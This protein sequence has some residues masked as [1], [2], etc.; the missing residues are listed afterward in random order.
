MK[1]L[2][3]AAACL[4]S[5]LL[6]NIS[7][8]Q[9][10]PDDVYY[11]RLYYTGKVWGFVKYFHSEVAKGT[12]NWDTSLFVTIANV[13][14]S[15]TNQDFNDAL[16]GLIDMAGE[17]ALPTTSLPYVHDSLKYNLNLNWQTD[18]IFSTEVLARLD[19][20]R[21]RFRP[22][23]NV[24]VGNVSG[25]GNPTFDND[26]QFYEWGADPYP[27]EELRLLALFRYWN[28]IN[29]FYPY[30][31]ILDQDW[32]STLAEFIPAM[33]N[34]HDEISFHSSFLAFITRLNDTHATAYSDVINGSIVGRYYL[35]LTLQYIENETVVTGVFTDN[36]FIQV[37]DVVRSL[38][39]LDI[40]TLRDSLRTYTSGSNNPA[41]EK[42]INLRLLRGSNEIVQMVVEDAEGQKNVTLA[43]D[44]YVSDYADLIARNDAVWSILDTESGRYGY[45]DM[46]RLEVTQ[47]DLMF[48]D[49]W[50]TDGII[51]D[52]RSYPQ[53]TMWS[54]IRY[55]FDA[56]IHMAK[57]TMPNIIF[58]GVLAWVN[59]VMVG[60]GDFSQTYGNSIFI[61]FDERTL[62]QAEYTV[63]AFERH[64]QAVKIGSQT[65]GADGNVSVIYL[66]G[67]ILTYF[68]GLGVF[69]PDYTET[70]RIGIVPD[71]EIHPTIA[72]IREGRDELLQAALQYCCQG[73]VGDA[74]NSEDDEPTISD[75]SA[76][77]DAK[78]ITGTCDGVI[79]CLT[80]A[81]INQSG[82]V[83]AT[84]D[85][86]TISDISTLIDY[87]FIT[88]VQL[89]LPD[90]L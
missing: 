32:D 57:F 65:S 42:N 84:C 85:D 73:R 48:N 31:Y 54:M 47:I 59:T 11:E 20:I 63:M 38:N 50:D 74:N 35:P 16:S 14:A 1:T 12:I 68:T 3:F 34:A 25:V 61:L 86:I 80:E 2:N 10:V 88:G 9:T 44:V 36:D 43:R 58:P 6:G 40:Y 18:E 13:Q 37:G 82:G 30:K 21:V 70:Q 4:V 19:T 7:H 69:Y 55:L 29:Y 89:G 90:C 83:L 22:Q 26:S 33:V 76:L 45:V 66:P 5:V 62:S 78:F 75:V 23:S 39:G 24:F 41:I 15:V 72:G 52:I 17:M 67:G 46:G 56:P 77:I 79:D 51:F 60:F 71:V 28:I 87:L 64:P 49:L 8:A 81:D 27:S 53:G